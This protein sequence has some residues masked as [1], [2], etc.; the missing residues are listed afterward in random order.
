VLAILVS[1]VGYN[2]WLFNNYDT[3]CGKLSHSMIQP[4]H[5][6]W[7]MIRIGD[8]LTWGERQQEIQD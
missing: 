4:E 5:T 8:V 6:A 3:S 2:A 1:L 7:L